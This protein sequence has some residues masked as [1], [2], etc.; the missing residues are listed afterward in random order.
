MI[1]KQ[2]RTVTVKHFQ[3]AILTERIAS[4]QREPRTP[5]VSRG[6]RR[7][8]RVR[9][10]AVTHV[11]ASAFDREPADD[12]VV[13][14]ADIDTP[15]LRVDEHAVRPVEARQVPVGERA[16]PRIRAVWMIPDADA[17]G[18]LVLLQRMRFVARGDRA[19]QG[20]F[21]HAGYRGRRSRHRTGI[22]HLHRVE[23]AMA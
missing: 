8:G 5:D 14:V 4:A 11:L 3:V 20:L 1:T 17:G 9:R 22:A 12:V 2:K 16:D 23:G 18:R 19:R 6:G 21:D 10:I 13:A 7:G 15:A